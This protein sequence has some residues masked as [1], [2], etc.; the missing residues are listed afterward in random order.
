MFTSDVAFC[1]LLTAAILEPEEPM[2]V[3]TLEL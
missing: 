1:C 2:E 3:L